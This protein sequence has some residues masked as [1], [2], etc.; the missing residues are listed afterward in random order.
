MFLRCQYSSKRKYS[1]KE[2]NLALARLDERTDDGRECSSEREREDTRE[3]GNGVVEEEDEKAKPERDDKST[4]NEEEEEEEEEEG[5]YFQDLTDL[6]KYLWWEMHV[7]IHLFP[8]LSSLS[9][10][11]S[12]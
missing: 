2:G 12:H 11:A 8:S 5:D 9:P 3:L 1:L 7:I 10:S 4:Q 6:C